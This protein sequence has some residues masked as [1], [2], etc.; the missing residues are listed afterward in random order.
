VWTCYP[1]CVHTTLR[2]SGAT[3]TPTAH[4]AP[5]HVLLIALGCFLLQARL[6]IEAAGRQLLATANTTG[7]YYGEQHSDC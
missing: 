6:G 5:H 2:H 4:M 1:T 7:I 3:A